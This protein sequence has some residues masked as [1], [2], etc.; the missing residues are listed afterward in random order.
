MMTAY[1]LTPASSPDKL[2]RKSTV[3]FPAP[4]TYNMII[5][6]ASEMILEEQIEE[7]IEEE[8]I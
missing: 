5:K 2:M 8:I 1:F 7:Q 6:C 3:D 4:I